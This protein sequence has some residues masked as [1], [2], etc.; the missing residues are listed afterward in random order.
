MRLRA[1]LAVLMLAPANAHAQQPTSTG[2]NIPLRFAWPAGLTATVE[3]ERMRVRNSAAPDSSGAVL[4]YRM[5]ASNGNDDEVMVRFSDFAATNADGAGTNLMEQLGGFVPNYRISAGG[6]FLG[7]HEVALLK[8]RMDSLFAPLL[9]QDSTGELARLFESLVSEEYL[10]GATAQ[11]WNALVGMWAGADLELGQVYELEEQA[12]LPLLPGATVKMVSEFAIEERVSCEEEGADRDCVQIRLYSEPDSAGMKA[13]VQQVMDRVARTGG[14]A[15]PVF[16]HLTIRSE[17]LLITRPE[18]LVPYYLEQV[19]V[20]EG[21]G[22]VAD[23][24]RDFAQ[25][26]RRRWWYSYK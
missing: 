12:A 1:L 21:R 26:D 19:K 22:R 25:T 4:S 16:E 14:A 8:A 5:Q 9:Q 18:T 15:V 17:L 2:E 11:E 23:Q 10:A 7:V 13:L 24:S 3:A 20:V 6:E